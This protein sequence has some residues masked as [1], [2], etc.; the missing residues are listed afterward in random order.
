MPNAPTDRLK[1]A[2]RSTEKMLLTLYRELRMFAA[3]HLRNERPGHTL[4]ATALVHEVFLKLMRSSSDWDSQH[5]FQASAARAMRRILVDAAR[6]KGSLKRGSQWN[7]LE[8]EDSGFS[9]SRDHREMIDLDDLLRKLDSLDSTA[10]L[11]V[12]LRVFAGMTFSEISAAIGEDRSAVYREWQFARAW[13]A[14]RLK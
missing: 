10:A 11:I 14:A 13:L 7:Q 12:E 1:P 5:H 6:R 2:H 9:R 4:Q 3:S 8:L